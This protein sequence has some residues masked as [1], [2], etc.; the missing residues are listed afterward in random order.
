MA[1]RP[2]TTANGLQ[3]P[4]GGELVNLMLPEAERQAAID[5]CTK[6][7]ECSDRNACHVELLF[8]CLLDTTDAP[9]E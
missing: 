7:N 8:V 1:A 9:D 3:A 4:H 6:T 2:S 5:S